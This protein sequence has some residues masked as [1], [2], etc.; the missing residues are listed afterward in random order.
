M[1]TVYI[2]KRAYNWDDWSL[3]DYDSDKFTP[4]A[5][6]DVGGSYT[7]AEKVACRVVEHFDRPDLKESLWKEI[8]AMDKGDI[9]VV[10]PARVELEFSRDRISDRQMKS[11]AGC[12][13]IGFEGKGLIRPASEQ[14]QA[15]RES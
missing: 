13:G 4:D 14:E 2:E 15:G 5:S 12:Y 3:R 8:A 9:I 7:C 6:G 1:R 10:K 11:D